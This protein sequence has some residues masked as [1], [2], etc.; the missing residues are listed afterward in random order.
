MSPIKGK[1]ETVTYS[2]SSKSCWGIWSVAAIR[3]VIA[4]GVPGVS[5]EAVLLIFFSFTVS[6]WLSFFLSP[7]PFPSFFACPF[8][9][10]FRKLSVICIGKR[11]S[12]GF[13][14]Y[15]KGRKFKSNQI[16]SQACSEL[17]QFLVFCMIP[18]HTR[19]QP[20][21]IGVGKKET[22]RKNNDDKKVRLCFLFFFFFFLAL[23]RDG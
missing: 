7:F 11:F 15:L 22:T 23:C 3:A 20:R 13:R 16:G 6:Y 10:V 4:P 18:M 19:V 17:M 12:K 9:T 2:Y 14:A 5:D 8:F 21:W 1:N